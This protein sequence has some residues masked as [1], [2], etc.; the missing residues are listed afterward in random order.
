MAVVGTGHAQRAATSRITGTSC[1]GADGQ[2]L[3][4]PPV[5]AHDVICRVHPLDDTAAARSTERIQRVCIIDRC[6]AATPLLQLRAS[7]AA[8]AQ[9]FVHVSI[10]ASLC[11]RRLCKGSKKAHRSG[12]E[13][14]RTVIPC[15][16]ATM[17]GGAGHHLSCRWHY[18]E[19]SVLS[20]ET[21]DTCGAC[22]AASSPH[23][24]HCC[25]PVL[26][27]DNGALLT[28]W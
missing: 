21:A 10:T 6:R 14:M 28:A 8:R 1:E 18:P 16:E 11:A 26:E 4:A 19:P 12:T 13:G 23:S 5:V 9:D 22:A 24:R 15:H 17:H 3:S 20:P 27:M 2:R 25:R 7:A